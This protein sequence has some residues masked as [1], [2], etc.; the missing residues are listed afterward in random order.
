MVLNIGFFWQFT[1]QIFNRQMQFY[2]KYF[3]KY[4]KL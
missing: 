4:V 3:I 1:T 2:M